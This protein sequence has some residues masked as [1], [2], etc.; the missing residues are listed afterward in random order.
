[1]NTQERMDYI[2]NNSK[3]IR[4]YMNMH[5]DEVRS[6]TIIQKFKGFFK[7]PQK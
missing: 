3:Y 5:D 1:M 4:M 6:K 7:W 2:L